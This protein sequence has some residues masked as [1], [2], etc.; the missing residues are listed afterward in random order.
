MVDYNLDLADPVTLFIGIIENNFSSVPVLIHTEGSDD[1]YKGGYKG[2]MPNIIPVEGPVVDGTWRPRKGRT[3]LRQ[4]PA[5]SEVTVYEVTD[6]YEVRTHS[7]NFA[8]NNKV[9]RV[10][11]FHAESKARLDELKKEIERCISKDKKNKAVLGNY[12][13]IDY[14]SVTPLTNRK[15][16]IFRYIIEYELVAVSIYTGHA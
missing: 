11:I 8:D 7:R 12:S 13:F 6:M 3:N 5:S 10:D 15:A 16:G 14:R 2:D 1:Y 9:I 4:E